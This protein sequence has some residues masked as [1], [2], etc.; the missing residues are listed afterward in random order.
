MVIEKNCMYR[1]Q[2]FAYKNTNRYLN[3][4]MNNNGYFF[5]NPSRNENKFAVV[6]VIK[7]FKN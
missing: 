2:K 7:H 5:S 6:F 3:P 4:P 1:K